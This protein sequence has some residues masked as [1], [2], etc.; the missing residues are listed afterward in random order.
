MLTSHTIA[1]YD[2]AVIP[3]Y[4]GMAAQLHQY[5]TKVFAQLFH[6]GKSSSGLY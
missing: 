4:S 5:G 1:G 3:A 6:G 2:K